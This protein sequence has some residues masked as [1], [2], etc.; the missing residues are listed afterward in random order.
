MERGVFSG[1]ESLRSLQLPAN[2]K[3]L[4]ELMISGTKITSIVIPKGV[5]VA[6]SG[7]Y[8]SGVLSGCET[9]KEVIFEE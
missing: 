9:L 8:G 2:V 1:C 7:S 4:G 5:E 3:H 6:E